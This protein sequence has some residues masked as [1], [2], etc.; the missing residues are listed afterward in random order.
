MKPRYLRS[1]A[2]FAALAGLCAGPARADISPHELTR[3]AEDLGL[4][5]GYGR[6]DLQFHL[7][8][9]TWF[10][11][12]EGDDS[13]AE[14]SQ[15]AL[16][17]KLRVMQP[18]GFNE[19]EL[20]WG[21]IWLDSTLGEQDAQI[22]QVGNVYAAHYWVWRTLSRQIRLGLGLGAPT[23][24]L[25]DEQPQQTINDLIALHSATGMRGARDLWLWA[26]QTGAV[27]GY[28]D[29]FQR[30]SFGL[31]IGGELAVANLYGFDDSRETQLFGQSGYNV[32]GQTRLEVGFDTRFLRTALRGTYVTVPLSEVLVG[33]ALGSDQTAKGWIIADETDQI[34]AELEFR[35]RLGR[36]DLVLRLDVP[37][38]EPFGFAFDE[39]KLWG[40]H[41]GVSSPTELRLPVD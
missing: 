17:P 4:G 16:S 5:P 35:I 1:A 9:G 2:A 41:I 21:F 39:G 33:Y 15:F 28:F 7:D 26:P 34:A 30:F 10:A 12:V 13:G 22:F 24:I 8:I 18:V 38:D 23:A 40:A 3:P 11:S 31:V 37:V 14:E 29:F 25:R 32:V 36:A 27:V 19:V 20:S 6:R